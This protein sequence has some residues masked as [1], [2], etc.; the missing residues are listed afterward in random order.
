M[1]IVAALSAALLLVQGFAAWRV[2]S[3]SF[4]QLQERQG[5]RSIDQALQ[6]IE[7]D[8]NQLAISAH[9]YAT[10][11]D[12]VEFVRTRDR[13]F[14]D[15]DL[16]AESLGNLKVDFVWMVDVEGNDVLSFQWIA[17]RQSEPP[18]AADAEIVELLRPR[19]AVMADHPG[20]PSLARLL[21]TRRGLLAVAANR[22]VTSAGRGPSRGT[23]VFGRF[24]GE[25]VVERAQTTSQLPLRLY[26]SAAAGAGLPAEARA[27][28]SNAPGGRDRVLVATSDAILS[29]F[30]LLRDVNDTP[31]AIVAVN[32]PRNLVSFGRQTGRSLVAIFSGVIA[33][34]AT[35]V[36]GLLL[37]LEKLGESRGAS[38][39]RYRAVITQAKETMLLVDTLSRKILE[40]NPAATATLGFSSQELLEMDV[41]ELFYACDGDVLK[42]VHAET[43]SAGT[44]DRILIVRCQNKDFIDVE[45]TASPLM[46]DEREV[47][48][49]VLRD[50]SGRKRAERQLVHNQDRLAHLA[51]HDMLTG[52]LNRLG[53]ERRLPEVIRK[54]GEQGLGVGFLYVDLDHFKKINDL[55]GHP[56]GDRL[57]R[58]AADR[59]RNCLSADDL[60]VRMGGDEFVVVAAGL[61]EAAHAGVIAGRIRDQLA[62]PFDVDDQH[63]KVTASIGVSV[64]PDDGADYEVLLK[65]A[66]IALYESK[67]AGRDAYTVFTPDMVR[68]VSEQIAFEVELR[69]AIQSGQFYLD[70]QPLVDSKTQRIASFEA[71]L[72]WHHPI[73]GRVPP[74]Q[75]IGIAERTGQICEIG[76]FVIREACRQIGEWRREGGQLIP[77][78][79]NVSTKQLE[80]R[81][82]VEVVKGALSSAQISPSLLCIEIT[83]SVFLDASDRRVQQL[84]ELRRLGV[85]VSVDDFGTGYSN[86]AYL[87]H[88][89]IDCLKIDRAFVR[90]INSG[91]ADEAIVKAIIRM[92]Q[93][94]GLS[95]VAEG[96][97]T[98]E[99]ARRLSELGVTCMQGFFFSPPL[100]AD[101]CGR[102]LPVE[103]FPESRMARPVLAK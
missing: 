34:F 3:G 54:A 2:I 62:Q 77:V 51:H 21:R 87:K 46:I 42:P 92:A 23:L 57:L 53:L 79:V 8:L 85:Q 103:R 13:H 25:A 4:A 81:N 72:R 22:I 26:P 28:W 29:G 69:E 16:T 5:E 36:G 49:F 68:R 35:V 83:E 67:E 52:L 61:R 60:I 56:C 12:A 66:D 88:L 55:R 78:A 89:P 70:Y 98:P 73:R 76:T 84:N 101:L 43:H 44:P 14:L 24:V 71:L 45:V 40:A 82:L 38:E 11:D 48:S 1:L 7:A 65:N 32:I 50:V 18:A 64:F 6:G 102:M 31:I 86:L 17:G 20:S 91:G 99:Q 47:T 41:D 94:I 39:R 96:V 95:T 27:L 74:L 100:A 30:A 75:F 97:E 10:W 37:Y 93:S 19:L 63:F 58:M 33:V 90:D 59:L 80:Q 15:S 9:D